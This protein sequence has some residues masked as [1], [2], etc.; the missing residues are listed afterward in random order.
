MGFFVG[1]TEIVNNNLEFRNIGNTCAI[2]SGE[3]SVP[4]PS[5][6]R[7]TLVAASYG[8]L[9]GMFSAN[10]QGVANS[11]LGG[12]FTAASTGFYPGMKISQQIGH[13]QNY[14][15]F[16]FANTWNNESGGPIGW[17]ISDFNNQGTMKFCYSFLY[18][19]TSDS[20][21]YVNVTVS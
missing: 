9:Y 14:N 7:V 4:S 16:L 8:V 17:Q 13:T 11:S 20:Y 10:V 6:T 12:Y 15:L 5:S 3:V 1:S 19:G 21:A 2:I 18:T